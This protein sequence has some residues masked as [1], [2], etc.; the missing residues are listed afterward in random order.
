[1]AL[2]LVMAGAAV[3]VMVAWLVAVALAVA[4]G[5]TVTVAAAVAVGVTPDTAVG[6]ALRVGA[7]G[8]VLV[9]VGWAVGAEVGEGGGV[10]GC[11]VGVGLGGA[12]GASVGEAT[13]VGE[14]SSGCSSGICGPDAAYIGTRLASTPITETASKQVQ[15]VS[16]SVR[17]KNFP[18]SGSVC[19]NIDPYLS[20]PAVIAG[21][22][23]VRTVCRVL[24]MERDRQIQGDGLVCFGCALSLFHLPSP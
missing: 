21:Q 18:R 22:R 3:G 19:L 2:L 14:S 20:A 1:M 17:N 12:V 9:L 16:V 4:V 24:D 10:V 6:D 15:M 7:G 11:A 13:T 8:G 23:L 5:V